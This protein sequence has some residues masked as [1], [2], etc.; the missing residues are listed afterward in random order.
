MNDDF[1]TSSTLRDERLIV[2]QTED[3]CVSL[4]RA[5]RT[6]IIVPLSAFPNPMPY[7]EGTVIRAVVNG[8]NLIELRGIDTEFINQHSSIQNQRPKLSKSL[9][10]RAKR[11]TNNSTTY[12]KNNSPPTNT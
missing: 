3:D 8:E 10:E 12:T 9:R 4:E 2:M 6:T 7:S 11:S 1:S 5:D